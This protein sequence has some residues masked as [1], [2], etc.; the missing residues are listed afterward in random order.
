[1]EIDLF[2]LTANNGCKVVRQ[3]VLMPGAHM[4]P[5]PGPNIGTP[6][7]VDSEQHTFSTPL[8]AN[9]TS[10]KPV[11]HRYRSRYHRHT[12]ERILPARFRQ[13]STSK[14]SRRMHR[15]QVGN[16]A[17]TQRTYTTGISQTSS[18]CTGPTAVCSGEQITLSYS[19][20]YRRLEATSHLWT[21]NTP[22]H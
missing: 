3:H 13:D 18:R 21:T 20:R 4:K 1:M 16:S 11:R 17:D 12:Y 7:F 8:A 5:V 22:Y 9:A 10:Y 15:T 14:V 2:V 19:S 6:S